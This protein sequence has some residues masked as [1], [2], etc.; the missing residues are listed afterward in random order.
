LIEPCDPSRR[1]CLRATL[2]EFPSSPTISAGPGNPASATPQNNETGRA[3][4]AIRL[5]TQCP[6]SGPGYRGSA[7]ARHRP[8][9]DSSHSCISIAKRIGT[10]EEAMLGLPRLNFWPSAA[11][12]D[13]KPRWCHFTS[14]VDASQQR[15]GIRCWSASPGSE[16]RN[17][18][19]PGPRPLY[20]ARQ[21]KPPSSSAWPPPCR[22][23]ARP[24]CCTSRGHPPGRSSG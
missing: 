16:S 5:T 24:G 6:V 8:S 20:P 4:V 11:P 12:A 7:W 1:F 14:G 17:R 3:G 10:Q 22:A 9:K 2:D 18:A 23:S 21:Q 19:Q 15:S 13:K